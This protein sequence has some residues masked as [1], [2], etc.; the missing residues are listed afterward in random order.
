MSVTLVHPRARRA[1]SAAR[2]IEKCTLFKTNRSLLEGPY[3]VKSSVHTEV[4]RAFVSALD[5]GSV[6]IT[7]SNIAGLSLLC[8]EFGFESLAA[9]LSEFRSSAARPGTAI[10]ADARQRFA[11]LEDRAQTRD[12]ETAVL[13]AEAARLSAAVASLRADV[14][15]CEARA[16]ADERRIDRLRGTVL[17][18]KARSPAPDSS[19]ALES[20]RATVR[21]SEAQIAAVGRAQSRTD[22]CIDG[23]RAEILELKGLPSPLTAPRSAQEAKE[24]EKQARKRREQEEK[25]RKK[26]EAE[27]KRSR[28]KAEAEEK[29]SRP[30]DQFP[31]VKER[32]MMSDLEWEGGRGPPYFDVDLRQSSLWLE[33]K[34]PID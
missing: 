3:A 22:A 23:L 32:E 28:K 7:N 2:L 17:A 25:D 13:Q 18:L 34:E 26:A 10:D 8:T 15:R 12:T 5:D 4:F 31:R 9:R 6:E 11:A 24:L 14:D 16:R 20:L 19:Q 27:E 33:T 1:V 21:T 30:K 29:R